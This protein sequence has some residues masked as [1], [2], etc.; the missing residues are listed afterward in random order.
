MSELNERMANLSSAKRALLKQ[1]LQGK[2]SVAGNKAGS[3][4]PT[5]QASAPLSFAQ[6]RMWFLDQF[7]PNNSFYSLPMSLSIKGTLDADVLHK[8]LQEIVRRHAVLRTRFE[9]GETQ[10]MQVIDPSAPLEM[11]L[12][13]LSS[14][15][16]RQTR[17]RGDAIVQGGGPAP[18]RSK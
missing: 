9:M 12:S 7:L 4:Q 3:I 10:P 5:E 1:R 13:D 8:S 14:L 11:P 17:S 6:E 18:L 16:L 2:V 15:S